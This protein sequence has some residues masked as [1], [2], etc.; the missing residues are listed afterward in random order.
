MMAAL[1]MTLAACSGP[2]WAEFYKPRGFGTMAP[3]PMGMRNVPDGQDSFSVGWRDGCNTYLGFTGSGLVQMRGFSYDIN[4][5]L[6]DRM[7]ATGFREGASLCM[8][9]SD[10]RPN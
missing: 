4:R 3:V 1:V 2:E 6:Q 7:Y 9:Y 10:T 8:Y 5:S